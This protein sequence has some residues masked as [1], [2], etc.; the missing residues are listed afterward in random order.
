MIPSG[1]PVTKITDSP[2]PNL[3]GHKRPLRLA[4]SP[5]N[6]ERGWL[7]SLTSIFMRRL[8][9]VRI[10]GRGPELEDDDILSPNT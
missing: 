4:V 3:S 2:A 9:A 6:I 5:T 7:T 8:L 1:Q 10:P